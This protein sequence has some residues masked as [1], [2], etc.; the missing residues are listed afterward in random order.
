VLVSHN[1]NMIVLMFVKGTIVHR[2][3]IHFLNQGYITAD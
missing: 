1:I 3:L 2:W